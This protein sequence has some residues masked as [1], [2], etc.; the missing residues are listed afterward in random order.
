[1]IIKD[2]IRAMPA[3]S[4]PQVFNGIK[5]N[6]NESPSDLPP[7][8][9]QA[10]FERLSA[11]EWNRYP[12]DD[13][14]QLIA[15]IAAYTGFPSESIMVGN[16]SN[17][18]IQA[19][20][21]SCCNTG[22]AIL[23]VSPTFSVYSRAAA[24]MNIETV[25]VPLKEDFSFDVPALLEAVNNLAVPNREG[26][27]TEKKSPVKIIFLASPN[28]PTGTVLEMKDIETICANTSSL[29]VMDEA[30]YEFYGES[31]LELVDKYPNLVIMRTFSKA[32]QAAGVRLGY[33]S[34]RPEVVEQLKKTKLPFSVGFFQQE[35]GTVLLRNLQLLENNISSI[36]TER[37]RVF[38]ALTKLSAVSPV[39]S[40]ANFILFGCRK[41][42]TF[43]V[44][45]SLKEKGVLVRAY[46]C[47]ELQNMLRAAIGTVEEN[48]TF[49][50]KL[51]E[52]AG[53]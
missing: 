48:D 13:A 38:D 31:A 17:E 52:V 41:K 9:K 1:M 26:P 47:P 7:V 11:C 14:G 19:L 37:E 33:L 12:L 15:E 10:I 21:Y 36:I 32:L 45:E 35:A 23:T 30:Y 29:L 44:Y 46:N 34:A 6:Q 16:S 25:T 28:N 51:E 40:K 53:K 8:I 42:P 24:V 2:N 22:D 49:L 27:V 43:E 5:L 18:L 3:Y 20:I 50:E 39:P 4:V